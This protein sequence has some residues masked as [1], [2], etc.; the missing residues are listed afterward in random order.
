MQGF[1]AFQL[2]RITE[3][4]KT[5]RCLY[6]GGA[7]D[8]HNFIHGLVELLIRAQS[9]SVIEIGCDRGISTEL[10]LLTNARVVA[11]DPWPHQPAYQEFTERCGAYPHLEIC[12]GRCPE[13]LEKFGAEFDLCYIDADHQYDAVRRDILA[14]TR[15]VKPQGWLGGH[16]YHQPQVEQAV[17]SM[18]D[19][20]VMFRDGSWLARNRLSERYLAGRDA[21][22]ESIMPAPIYATAR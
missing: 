13:A 14:A 12:R 1:R 22:Q 7:D 3:L 5:T 20:P 10:F 8:V 15:V 9:K 11:V 2:A 19:D 18:I 16:D 4:I 6:P 17:R 21:D